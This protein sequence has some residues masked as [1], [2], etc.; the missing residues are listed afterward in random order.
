MMT[1]PGQPD[2]GSDPAAARRRRGRNIAMLVMLLAVAALFYGIAMVKM[3]EH[4]L[5]P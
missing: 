2:P 3:A 1:Q 4:G 5:H